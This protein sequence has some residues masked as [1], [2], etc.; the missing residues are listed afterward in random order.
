MQLFSCNV[1]HDF[2]K[3]HPQVD[4]FTCSKSGQEKE[5]LQWQGKGYAG[6]QYRYC[7]AHV[8]PLIAAFIERATGYRARLYLAESRSIY[9]DILNALLEEQME[10]TFLLETI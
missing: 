9:S 1:P 8:V 6:G 3:F 7:D 10:A 5:F 2:V 4:F